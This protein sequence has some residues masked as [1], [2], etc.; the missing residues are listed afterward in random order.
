MALMIAEVPQTGE[1]GAARDP[2][3][4]LPGVG[5]H[6]HASAI[7]G[8]GLPPAEAAHAYLFHGPPGTGKRSVARAF[9]AALLADGRPAQ[10]SGARAAESEG[11]T[12]EARAALIGRVARGTH[13]DLTWVRPS[14]AAEM[15]V[16]DIDEAVVGA[17]SRT[18]FEAGRRVFVI[19]GAERMNDQAA[20]RLLKT[21]EEPPPWVHLLLIAQDR[22][23][24]LPT[25]ASRCQ[26]VRFDPLS[27]HALAR[28][29]AAEGVERSE[30]QACARLAL[31]DGRLARALAQERGRA[32]RARAEE[33]VGAAASGGLGERPWLALLAGAREDGKAAAAQVRARADEELELLGEKERRGRARESQESERR[34]DRRARV[35]T[36]DLGLRL[37]EL[38]LRDAWCLAV[39]APAALHAVDRLSS[40]QALLA[41]LGTGAA[42][43]LRRGVELVGETRMRLPLNVSEE[44]AIEALAYR[45]A[46]ALAG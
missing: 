7:L 22:D 2:D 21:L 13:P 15:L 30:A 39:G 12:D 1:E 10:G 36:L 34:A 24:V 32:L 25:V 41:M 27:P 40:L 9:A 18:P 31:G 23:A 17:A 19:E 5:A 45:L 42:G 38:W 46:A 29:L 28:S 8:R 6:P 16:G 43:C 11:R 37:A 44:L 26:P 33:L 35:G 14:G 4:R 3:E 20:N